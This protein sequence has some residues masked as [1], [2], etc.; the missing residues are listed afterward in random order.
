MHIKCSTA[1]NALTLN[2]KLFP[3]RKIFWDSNKIFSCNCLKK[4]NLSFGQ[5]FISPTKRLYVYEIVNWTSLY[6][7]SLLWNS[8][9]HVSLY[10]KSL[11]TVLTENLYWQPLLAQSLLTQYLMRVF[12]N[13][14]NLRVNYDIYK[15]KKQSQTKQHMDKIKYIIMQHLC[16]EAWFILVLQFH[17]HPQVIHSDSCSDNSSTFRST[18]TVV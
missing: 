6:W 13:S 15:W 18:T 10:W 12:T 4:M 16:C 9:Y 7:H 2:V 5:A 11:L 14:V 8:C 3:N 1:Y 17:Q